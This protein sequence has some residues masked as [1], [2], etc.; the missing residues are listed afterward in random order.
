MK[1]SASDT[2]KVEKVRGDLRDLDQV[3]RD[4]ASEFLPKKAPGPAL[5]ARKGMQVQVEG[6]SMPGTVVGDPKNG[7]VAVQVGMVRITVAMDR[8]RPADKTAAPVKQKPNIRLQKT[9]HAVTEI[10]LRH[11]RAEEAVREL[12]RF[13]DDAVLAGL[14]NIRIVHGKGEG[15]L[16]KATQNFLRHYPSVGTFRDGE[17]AEGGQ[18]VTIAALA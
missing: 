1:A 5:D 2:R 13:L 9:L 11:L 14:D 12:E 10:D 16:R 8:L 3:G 18:G 7:E 4:F 17:P 6:F 15:V